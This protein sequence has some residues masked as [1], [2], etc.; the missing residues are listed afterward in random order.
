MSKDFDFNVMGITPDVILL[1][2]EAQKKQENGEI[3]DSETLEALKAINVASKIVNTIM[4]GNQIDPVFLKQY[5]ENAEKKILNSES[6]ISNKKS[7]VKKKRRFKRK[8]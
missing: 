3:K 2:K 1:L 5:I 6:K 4:N 7:K 8:N